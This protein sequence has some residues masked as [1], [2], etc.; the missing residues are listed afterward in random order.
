MVVSK[1]TDLL[2]GLCWGDN[3]SDRN[4]NIYERKRLELKCMKTSANLSFR[5]VKT[6]QKVHRCNLRLTSSFSDLFLS[7]HKAFQVFNNA[8]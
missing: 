6:D 1:K 4:W 8:F 3:V 5:S 7:K 2:I